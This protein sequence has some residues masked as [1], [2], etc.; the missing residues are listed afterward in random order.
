MNPKKEWRVGTGKYT[1]IPC[2][3]K[4]CPNPLRDYPLCG[5]CKRG[6]RLGR[7]EGVPGVYNPELVI[8]PGEGCTRYGDREQFC[9]MHYERNQRRGRFVRAEMDPELLGQ[10]CGIYTCERGS[11][12]FGLCGYHRRYQRSYK[13]PMKEFKEFWNGDPKCQNRNCGNKDLIH[14]DHDHK[15]GEFRG[16]LCA[17]CNL[18]LGHLKDKISIAEGLIDYMRERVV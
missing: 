3:I 15:T 8:C 12:G 5:K 11:T 17:T 9:D 1:G 10:A 4:D 2:L 7:I 16:F 18:A 13:V 6:I 14:V